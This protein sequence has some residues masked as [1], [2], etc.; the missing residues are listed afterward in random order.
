MHLLQQHI[1]NVQCSS[2]PLG[3]EIQ[4]TLSDVLEKEFYPKLE[5]LLDKYSVENY[6][7]TIDQLTVELPAVSPKEWKKELVNQSLTRIEDYLKN[8]F[9]EVSH[10]GNEEIL[11]KLGFETVAFH[12]VNLLIG[13]LKTGIIAENSFSGNINEIVKAIEISGAFIEKLLKVFHSHKKAFI[14]YYFNIPDFFRE[15]IKVEMIGYPDAS[16]PLSGFINFFKAEIE[17]SSVE[18]MEH[19][20]ENSGLYSERTE[21][22]DDTLSGK[23]YNIENQEFS[24]EN[25]RDIQNEEG[26]HL[27]LNK[28][29]RKTGSQETHKGNNDGGNE[30]NT[31]NKKTE[32]KSNQKNGNNKDVENNSTTEK[33]E[34]SSSILMA[35]PLYVENAGLVILH[36]FLST[37][38]KKLDMCHD[39]AWTD[40]KSQHK[41]IL[42]TQYL[43]TGQEIFFENE[44]VLNKLLCGFPIDEVVNTRQKISRKEKETCNDL[45]LAVIEHWAMLKGSSVSALRET[46]LQRAGK[47]SAGSE[48]HFPELWVE[49]K[50][51]DV[52]LSGLPWGIGMIQTPWMENYMNV[53]WTY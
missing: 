47:L 52:L 9:R 36:P 37:L 49:E 33:Q 11:E 38:F 29:N 19:W 44:L 48:S 5:I 14:R 50:G 45:L 3:K 18:E 42:L 31:Q 25:E 40:K 39:E 34:M 30:E 27:E 16:G 12:S 8:H 22:D 21:E 46:F 17:F 26:E 1:M 24:R 10:N 2:Q 43:I 23:K 28:N 51:V 41:A 35:S 32:K 20:V 13:Y 6:T 15:K 7:W 53:Y 4:N